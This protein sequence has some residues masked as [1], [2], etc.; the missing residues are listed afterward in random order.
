MPKRVS[1]SVVSFSSMM[2][3]SESEEDDEEGE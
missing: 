2:Y 1:P 3:K